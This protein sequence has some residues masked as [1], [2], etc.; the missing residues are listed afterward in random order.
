MTAYALRSD[1]VV[2]RHSLQAKLYGCFGLLILI[3]IVLNVCKQG[4]H[5]DE[6]AVEQEGGGGGESDTERLSGVMSNSRAP[7]VRR[8]SSMEERI[9]VGNRKSI[10][11]G[12]TKG[13]RRGTGALKSA[14]KR[15]IAAERASAEEAI[16]G[17]Q[18]NE[19]DGEDA[20]AAISPGYV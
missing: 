13:A 18:L 20:F 11:D 3:A 4:R 14:S 8:N 17:A 5:K 19:D 2:G 1:R 12:G 9:S 7:G 16:G 15:G 10:W 6:E